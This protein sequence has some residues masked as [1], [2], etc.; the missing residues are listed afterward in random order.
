M[1]RD[2]LEP[3]AALDEA[4]ASASLKKIHNLAT[5]AQLSHLDVLPD[6]VV[7]TA[8]QNTLQALGAYSPDV[9][10]GIVTICDVVNNVD[11]TRARQTL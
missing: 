1:T 5:Q 6:H 4:A 3:V 7:P 11:F 10:L 8:L 9:N 2:T